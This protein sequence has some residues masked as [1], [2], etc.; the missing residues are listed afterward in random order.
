MKIS[1][2]TKRYFFEATLQSKLTFVQGISSAGKST[3]ADI[4]DSVAARDKIMCSD[5][6]TL[7]HLT[8]SIFQSILRKVINF[9]KRKGIDL[10]ESTDKSSRALRNK[11]LNKYWGDVNNREFFSS[12]L[13]IDEETFVES[14]DFACFYNNDKENY[15]F[16]IDRSHL[17]KINYGIED[18]YEFIKNGREHYL[19]PLYHAN[20][21]QN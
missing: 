16:I 1:I 12:I 6:F 2:N 14:D 15:Y 3:F 7:V 21:P 4:I 13:V 17:H 19:K 20:I 11:L 9:Y 18:C 5:G 10:P 8:D